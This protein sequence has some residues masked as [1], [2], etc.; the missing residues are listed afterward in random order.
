MSESDAPD[1]AA[2]PRIAWLSSIFWNFLVFLIVIVFVADGAMIGVKLLRS[3]APGWHI[4]FLKSSAQSQFAPRARDY[5][6]VLEP[7]SQAS[8]SAEFYQLRRM[9]KYGNVAYDESAVVVNVLRMNRSDN[10]NHWLFTDQKRA[11]LETDIF[12]EHESGPERAQLLKDGVIAMVVAE[13]DTNKDG[14]IGIGDEVSLY[15]YRVDSQ[16][17]EKLLTADQITVKADLAD[18]STRRVFYQ[19]AKGTFVATL[20]VPELKLADPAP[21]AD[22]PNMVAQYLKAMPD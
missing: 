7:L 9:I 21:I 4:P 13:K 5:A 20:K 15:V 10:V 8:P 17:L 2:R 11:I 19:N 14:G 16:S 6:F 22:M 1:K 18:F 12:F 3:V